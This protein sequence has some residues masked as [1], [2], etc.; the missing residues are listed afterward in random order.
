MRGQVDRAHPP[1]AD[2]PPEGVLAQPARL[3]GGLLHLPAEHGVEAGVEQQD[4]SAED[5]DQQQ[6]LEHQLQDPQGLVGLLPVDL[7]GHSEAVLLQPAPGAHHRHPA[8]VP[9]ALDVDPAP[10]PGRLLHQRK[11]GPGAGRILRLEALDEIPARIA[12][13]QRQGRALP[14]RQQPPL[15]QEVLEPAAREH[16]P[17]GVE[18]EGL[19]GLPRAGHRQDPRELVGGAQ[20]QPQGRDHLLSGGVTD[21]SGHGHDGPA[22]PSP[23]GPWTGACV[24]PAPPA[25]PGR[26]RFRRPLRGRPALPPRSG[27]PETVPRRSALRPV[28]S[29]EDRP[30]LAEQAPVAFLHLLVEGH[31]Q[32]LVDRRG[33]HR[34]FGI[35]DHEAHPAVGAGRPP[36]RV[37]GPPRRKRGRRAEKGSEALP[38]RGHLRAAPQRLGPAAVP[39]GMLRDR[40]D[41]R[42]DPLLPGQRLHQ[43]QLVGYPDLQRGDVGLDVGADLLIQLVVQCAAHHGVAPPAGQ[44][45]HR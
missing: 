28:G 22:P 37:L 38:Q 44:G 41:A 32:H 15:P 21:R 45:H 20:N 33:D 25:G 4:Q 13:L 11:Q 5:R 27:A 40:L 35:D 24:G 6:D 30:L 9:E 19:P 10:L 42:P 2:L 34:S 7:G 23:A 31:A 26:G 3:Q 17:L 16:Q 39:R 8:V 12:E 18:G 36:L 14:R 29:Q 1:L 43:A